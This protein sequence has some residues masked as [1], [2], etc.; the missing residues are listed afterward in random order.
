MTAFSDDDSERFDPAVV[1]SLEA[2]GNR[3]RLEILFVLA[4]RKYALEANSTAMSFTELYDA[5]DSHSTS[6]FS[7][8]L[9]RLVGAFVVETPDGYRLTYAGDKV[10][11]AV[12]SGLYDSSPPLAPLDISGTC[13]GCGGQSLT[14]RSENDRFVVECTTCDTPVVFDLYP[15]SISRDR[16]PGEVVDSFGYGIWAKFVFARGGVCPECFG[17][18]ETTFDR[19]GMGGQPF[20]V[21]VNR[22]PECWFTVYIPVDVVAAFHPVVMAAL[23]EHGVSVFDVPLWELFEYTTTD[24]WRSTVVSD[25]PFTAHVEIRLDDVRLRIAVDD[26]LRPSLLKKESLAHE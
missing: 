1:E 9:Q 17:P 7:Y 26:A 5:V 13:P 3:Q 22:C 19:S 8:H 10:R 20:V 16:S 12:V 6:Q 4:E 21:A 18:V 14:A 23:W 15:R 24:A 11:R 25:D 2:L